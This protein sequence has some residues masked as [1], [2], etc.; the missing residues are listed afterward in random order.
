MGSVGP[1]MPNTKQLAPP[2]HEIK[3]LSSIPPLSKNN[4]IERGSSDS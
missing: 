3:Y 2:I 4:K 1:E